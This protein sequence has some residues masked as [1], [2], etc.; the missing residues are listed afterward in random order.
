MSSKFN[1]LGLVKQSVDQWLNQVNYGD[2]LTYKP[3][4][5]ALAF[6]NFIK[7]VNGG[8][9]EENTTPVLHLKML[10]QIDRLDTPK[11]A[12]MV[13]R[14]AAK[15]TVLGEYLLLYLAV[16]GEL[17][18]FGKI[19]LAIY[20]SDSVENGVKNMR[21]NLE[22]RRENSSYGTGT[23]KVEVSNDLQNW[24]TLFDVSGTDSI[25]LKHPWKYQKVTNPSDLEVYVLQGR[26]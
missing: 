25:V 26:H 9:G 4:A 24:I 6:V 3:S 11:I 1:S 16:F 23:A 8:S 20:V 15:T 2:D 10:D 5:F 12:N 21:K 17:P 19:N 22:Y 14:G 18:T 13:F 7:L